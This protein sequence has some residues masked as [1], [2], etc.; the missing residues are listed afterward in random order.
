MDIITRAM[1]QPH[2][3]YA[4]LWFVATPK[5]APVVTL[6]LNLLPL[7]QRDMEYWGN[8]VRYN[9]QGAERHS[10]E[11]VPCMKWIEWRFIV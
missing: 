10:V 4:T 2:H 7:S 5:L 1:Q 3:H 6:A 9:K 11:D 8:K